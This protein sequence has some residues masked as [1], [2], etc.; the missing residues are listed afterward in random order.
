MV[1][2][3]TE[4][5]SDRERQHEEKPP[6]AACVLGS[7][8]AY[9]GPY[10][11]ASQVCATPC[12]CSSISSVPWLAMACWALIPGPGSGV[13]PEILADLAGGGL[14]LCRS[15]PPLGMCWTVSVRCML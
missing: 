14:F 15:G 12:P 9:L 8:R 2:Q 1:W 13:R 10:I 6:G 4:V 11:M 5:Y 3:R 7:K